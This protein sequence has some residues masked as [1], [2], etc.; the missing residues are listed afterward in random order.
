MM[1]VLGPE[2]AVP[3]GVGC[4]FG[5]RWRLDVDTKLYHLDT[6]R[7]RRNGWEEDEGWGT[8]RQRERKAKSRTRKEGNEDRQDKVDEEK[9]FVQPR[10]YMGAGG[11]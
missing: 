6:A 2:R 11:G 8:Y 5:R 3:T 4:W 9:S 10:I 1:G 7:G